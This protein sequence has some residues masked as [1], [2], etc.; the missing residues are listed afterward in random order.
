MPDVR[1]FSVCD[2]IVLVAPYRQGDDSDNE[3]RNQALTLN[4]SGRAIWELCDGTR[5]TADIAALLADRH[6]VDRNL[7]E[8][9]V[10][11]AL[12]ELSRQGFVD[13]L[14]KTLANSPAMTFVVGIEDKAYFHWQ[15]AIFLESLRGK[16]PPGWKTFVVVCNNHQPLSAELALV[17]DRYDTDFTFAT[18]HANTHLIDVGHNGGETHAALNRVEALSAAAEKVGNSEMICLLDTD[19]FLYGDLNLDIVPAGCA[20]PRN[21]HIE[22]DVFFATVDENKGN[23][24]DLRK[25]LDALGC[26]QEFQPGGVNIFVTGEV[27]KNKKFIADCFRFAHALFLLGRAAGVEIAWIAEMPCFALAM[28][29]NCISY[30]LLENKEFLVSDCTEK[31]IPFGTLYHYYCDPADFGQA[32]FHGSKWHKQAYHNENFLRSDLTLFTGQAKTDHERY[33]F[34]LAK[35]AQD[36]LDA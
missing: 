21:W 14:S 9:Q 34:Q 6:G 24:V 10:G 20:M 8:S 33:F 3:G 25:L 28:T 30:D 32:A 35:A 17:L 18:N 22:K 23:G 27:A 16:L 19:I 7:L 31:S 5:S 29:A 13:G 15:T 1:Q 11:Q 12:A 2:E 26:K 36:R 4:S